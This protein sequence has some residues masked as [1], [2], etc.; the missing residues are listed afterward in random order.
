MANYFYGDQATQPAHMLAAV[1][2]QRG[3]IDYDQIRIAARQGTGNK[4]QM[5]GGGSV[6]SGH[7]A[8]YDANGNV[9]DGGSTPAGGFTAAGDLSGSSSSQTVV[10]LQGKPVISTAPTDGQVLTYVGTD[11][12]WEPKPASGIPGGAGVVYNGTSLPAGGLPSVPSVIQSRAQSN[13]TSLAFSSNVTSGNLLVALIGDEAAVTTASVSDTRGSSWSSAIN[14]TGTTN[15]K[16]F[17]ALAASSGANT[18]TFT[19]WSSP[20]WS[21]VAIMEIANTQGVLDGTPVGTNAGATSPGSLTTT[22]ANSIAVVGLDGFHSGT[23][24]TAPSGWTLTQNN[25]HDAVG[26]AWMIQPAAGT[27][28]PTFSG[29]ST[30]NDSQALVAFKASGGGAFGG[31][32]NDY[33]FK[34]DSN[35]LYGPKAGGVWPSAPIPFGSVSSVGLSMPAEFTVTGSPVTSSGTLAVTKA[36]ETANTVWAGPS[37]GAAA[38]PAFRALAAADIPQVIKVNG[39]PVGV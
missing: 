19:G 25:G 14:V 34:T 24:W 37:S 20:G 23:T 2:Q 29:S 7:V 13:A 9:V 12:K 27:V 22:F 26:I 8:V 18:V 28:N 15:L 33:Y 1:P 10:G 11:A 32:N 3:N 16:I 38:A 30:D 31:S 17:Y 39:T 35:A 5:F 4:L 6:T 21:N 36:N